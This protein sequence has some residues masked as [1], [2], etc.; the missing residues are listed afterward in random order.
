MVM[1]PEAFSELSL[2]MGF[3]EDFSWCG[4]DCRPDGAA[5]PLASPGNCPSV[6]SSWQHC[7]APPP[8]AVAAGGFQKHACEVCANFEERPLLESL[9]ITG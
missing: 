8:G 9:R 4:S 2:S 6:P 3:Q 1:D 7:L 5:L